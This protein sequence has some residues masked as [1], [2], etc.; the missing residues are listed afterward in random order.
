VHGLD[1]GAQPQVDVLLRVE[2]LVVHPVGVLRV[3]EE[4][5]LGQRGQLV[6]PVALLTEEEQ[7]A[8]ETLL[9]QRTR[10]RGPGQSG[11]HDHDAVRFSHG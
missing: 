9:A 1:P 10:C 3:A 6:G 8:V 4:D 5:A 2:R 7:L 11:A